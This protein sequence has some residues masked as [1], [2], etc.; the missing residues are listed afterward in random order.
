MVDHILLKL[1]DKAGTFT[2]S[3]NG[4]MSKKYT[5]SRDG[6]RWSILGHRNWF[7]ACKRG[8]RGANASYD[9]LNGCKS[10]H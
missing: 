2:F 7:T 9:T 1:D 5:K 10:L 3:K 6:D 8:S 4:G